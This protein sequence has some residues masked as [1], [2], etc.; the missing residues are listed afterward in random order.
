MRKYLI[1]LLVF[2]FSMILGVVLTLDNWRIQ[3]G[4]EDSLLPGQ[5]LPDAKS[6]P[7]QAQIAAMSLEEKVGQ[8]VM[9]GVDRYTNDAHS[10]QLITRYHVGG[11]VLLKQN[12]SNANQMLS[13][14]NSLK[15]TNTV[16]KVP[17]LLSIDE[18]GGRISRMP[19]E[20]MKI[21]AS[22]RIGEL[23]QKEL[24]YEVGDV[25]GKE[26]RAFGLNMNFAPVLDINSNPK[27]PVI[28]DRALGDEPTRVSNLGIQTMKGLQAQ[29][30]ISVV[31]HFPGHGDTSVDSH[32]G[33]PMVNH[34]LERLKRLELIPFS[35][36]I[37]NEVDVIMLAHI[38]LPKIDQEY[39]AS[40]SKI[41]ITDLLRNEMKFD[42]VVITDDMTMGAI[43]KNYD[44]GEAAVKSIQ[45]GSDIV[46]VCHDYLKEEAVLKA[47]RK[48]A[49]NGSIS[50]DRIDQSVYRILKLKQK[51]TVTDQTV[52]SVDLQ[53]LNSNIE[54]LYRNYPSLKN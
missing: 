13:L 49:E 34:D 47:I 28:G 15:E 8:L 5:L 4:K 7:I 33:L 44:I 14:I 46:L 10:Q 9:V 31:K 3:E 27:N 51:Y 21:P 16:N 43:V 11:F 30:I 26:L 52:K 42:G 35:A 18:E 1:V 2:T 19:D 12:I 48:A 29:N 24:S 38:L 37:E 50:E 22:Q 53:R 40:F 23:N 36:A 25:I 6:D 20:L 32:I 41:V 17:L 39:P 45:A 54:G